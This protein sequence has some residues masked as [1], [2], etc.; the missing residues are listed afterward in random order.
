[1]KESLNKTWIYE[2]LNLKLKKIPNKN[3]TTKKKV[4]GKISQKTSNENWK[5]NIQIKSYSKNY[6]YYKGI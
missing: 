3:A 6:K 5:K 2:K 4:H 1:M